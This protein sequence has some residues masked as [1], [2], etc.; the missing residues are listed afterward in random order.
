MI[1]KSIKSVAI[2]FKQ[3]KSMTEKGL[4][5]P[6]SF[7]VDYES[8]N[9]DDV[10]NLDPKIVAHVL[11]DFTESYIKKIVALNINS[12]H[13]FRPNESDCNFIAAYDD[14]SSPS[15]RGTRILSKINLKT[16]IKAYEIYLAKIGKDPKQISMHTQI[17]ESKFEIIASKPDAL[18]VV[19]GLLT[20]FEL[21]ESEN[22]FDKNDLNV[23]N[24]VHESLN[25]KLI[26]LIENN[27][28]EISAANL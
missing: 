19:A 27:V 5:A 23:I 28:E 6:E 25:V 12:N 24:Q 14:F 4:K 13:D 21:G 18:N 16:F 9:P 7:N 2:N 3:T 10:A 17:I 11:N 22:N 15:K 20:D 1:T 8:I 26:E